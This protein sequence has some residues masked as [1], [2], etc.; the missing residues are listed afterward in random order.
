MKTFLQS[1]HLLLI[2]INI[3]LCVAIV[4]FYLQFVQFLIIILNFSL[5][6]VNLFFFQSNGVSVNVAD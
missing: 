5:A 1:K 4:Y 6:T 3:Y 2:K